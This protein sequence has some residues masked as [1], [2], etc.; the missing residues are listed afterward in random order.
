MKTPLR[1]SCLVLFSGLLLLAFPPAAEAASADTSRYVSKADLAKVVGTEVQGLSSA[2]LEPDD[3]LGAKQQ[4]SIYQA[5]EMR[6]LVVVYT[7]PSAAA[8]ASKITAARVAALIDEDEP[9]HVKVIEEHGVGDRAF[10]SV[11]DSGV[12]YLVVKGNQVLVVSLVAKLPRPAAS[13]H[14]SLKALAASASAKL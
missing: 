5:G 3:E 8:A 11:A 13:Y 6:I 7:F 12:G 4:V 1:R 2:P 9:K 10:W 14:D